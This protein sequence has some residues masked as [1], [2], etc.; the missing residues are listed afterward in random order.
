MNAL[1]GMVLLFLFGIAVLAVM[2]KKGVALSPNGKRYGSAL[3][4]YVMLA[5]G[6]AMKWWPPAFL[7]TALESGLVA[8]GVFHSVNYGAL[9][10]TGAPTAPVVPT[11]PTEPAV[12]TSTTGDTHVA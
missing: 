3:F 5:V 11:A 7:E 4:F 6:V 2:L 8:L 9:N 10:L 12:T 1:V